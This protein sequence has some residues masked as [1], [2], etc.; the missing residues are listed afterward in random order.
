MNMFEIALAYVT[1]QAFPVIALNG[2]ETPAEVA[3]SAKA[4]GLSLAPAER[5]WLDL[6]SD[7]KPF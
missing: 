2:A 1:S 6:S 4:G 3:S 7:S 5:D